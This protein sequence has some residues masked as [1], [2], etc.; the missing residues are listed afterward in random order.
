MFY[1][2]PLFGMQLMHGME[3]NVSLSAPIELHSQIDEYNSV[4]DASRAVSG[5]T[6]G[7]EDY[8]VAEKKGCNAYENYSQNW[9]AD[10][11]DNYKAKKNYIKN[12]CV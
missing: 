11:S 1:V 10:I 6:C 9:F 8:S 12:R 3:N 5:V 4:E 7:N 2:L